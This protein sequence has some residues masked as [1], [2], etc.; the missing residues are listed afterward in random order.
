MRSIRYMPG[1][2]VPYEHFE[3]KKQ[4]KLHIV[5]DRHFERDIAHFHF[6][7]APN[8]C[9]VCID[10]PKV[11]IITFRL[12][13]DGVHKK[14]NGVVP[15]GDE[16]IDGKAIVAGQFYGVLQGKFALAVKFFV[17][18]AFAQVQD[19]HDLVYQ[20]CPLR[21]EFLQVIKKVILDVFHFF[22]HGEELNVFYLKNR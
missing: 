22:Y 20:G 1:G 16:L 6:F 17:G 5:K 7:A 4:G 2:V 13:P 18:T 15:I 11:L 21:G 3:I 9:Q 14:G 10:I 8:E 19:R 12:A